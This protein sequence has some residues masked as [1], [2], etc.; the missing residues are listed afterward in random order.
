MLES[1]KVLTNKQ[2]DT[3]AAIF[4]FNRPE[5]LEQ[6]LQSIQTNE[7]LD[8]ID[9]YFFQDGE[10]NKFS[11]RVAGKEED[12]NACLSLWEKAEIPNKHLIYHDSNV[13]IGISQFEAKTLLFD[14]KQYERAMFFEDDLVLG[15][16]YLKM[17]GILLD[18][19][20]QET[21]V[22]A[23]MCHGGHPHVFTKAE[24]IQHLNHVRSGNDQ[25]WG[26]ATWKDRW[27][28]IKSNFLKY[29]KFIENVD[30]P[31]KPL[32]D[33][34]RFYIDEGINIK[35]ASQDAALHYAF[36]KNNLFILNT[37]I[38]RAIYIGE[39]G[40]HM[41]PEK[42]QRLGFV[43]ITLQDLDGDEKIEKFEKYDKERFLS[44]AKAI[45]MLPA[46]Q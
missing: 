45:F 40:Q 23:V 28:R 41:Y 43:N 25:L 9:F 15:S 4:S 17:L 30:Y 36:I 18:Q 22:G 39:K 34:L 35:V 7:R 44:D 38:H 37:V 27:E 26:W 29:Y 42:Y 3:A 11:G 31:K 19:F 20:E 24:K 1:S 10:I 2:N 46:S 16:H 33:I 8:C 14:E 6:V 32:A 12:I 13:G 5:Y 21:E